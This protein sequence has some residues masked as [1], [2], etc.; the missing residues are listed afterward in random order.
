MNLGGTTVEDEEMPTQV[1]GLGA[2]GHAKVVIDILIR[3]EHRRLAGLLDKDPA[4]WGREVMGL[5]VLGGDELLPGLREKGFAAF[6]IGL[7][8]VGDLSPRIALFEAA[9]AAGLT[10]VEAVHPRAVVAE[11][12]ILGPGITIMAGA[13]INPGAEL[14]KNVIVNTGAVVE[15]DCLIRDHAHIATGA[16][17]SGGVRVGRAAHVGAGAVVRQGLTI[18]EEALVG[19]GAMVVEDVADGA[20]V[21]GNP[22]RTMD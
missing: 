4:L 18:G 11:S 8:G 15:H 22:A 3:E 5:P 6:F 16:V 21:V 17:L 10:P 19:A 13:V 2:G 20:V 1:I 7:G 14:G 12:A 9:L